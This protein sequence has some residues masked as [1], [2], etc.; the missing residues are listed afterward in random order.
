[1]NTHI[2]TDH[3]KLE[4][5]STNV[6][7]LRL[8]KCKGLS[9]SLGIYSIVVTTRI[10]ASYFI[11]IRQVNNRVYARRSTTMQARVCFQ[12]AHKTGVSFQAFTSLNHKLS[13]NAL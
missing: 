1:M 4:G 5:G 10:A 6:T 13:S 7:F 3:L 12:Y 9:E 11:H 2:V 8:S